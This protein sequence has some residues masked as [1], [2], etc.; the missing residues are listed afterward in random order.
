MKNTQDVSVTITIEGSY[1][2]SDWYT[3]KDNITLGSNE[4]KFGT[5][6]APFGYIRAKAVAS[7]TPSSGSVVVTV[8]SMT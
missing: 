1:D 6:K 7:S 4:A 8:A 3:I 5:L 2:G